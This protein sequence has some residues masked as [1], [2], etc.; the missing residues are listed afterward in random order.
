MRISEDRLEDFRSTIK[1]IV[2]ANI[3]GIDPKDKK[4]LDAPNY[5]KETVH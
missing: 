3:H 5:G 4:E 1:E 2:D